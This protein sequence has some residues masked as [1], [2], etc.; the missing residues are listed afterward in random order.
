MSLLGRNLNCI[1]RGM[2]PKALDRERPLASCECSKTEIKSR[3]RSP[4]QF[5]IYLPSLC[6]AML[7]LAPQKGTRQID[8][9][10]F[11]AA[12][13][14]VRGGKIARLYDHDS[15]RNF[16]ALAGK[17]SLY[18]N[19]PPF[20]A[21]A[22]L[23]FAYMSYNTFLLTV[24]IGSYLLLALAVWLIP[25]WFP[26]ITHARPLLLCFPPFLLSV[27]VGQDTIFLTL[28]VGYGAYLILRNKDLEGGITLA[29]AL[30][31][32]HLLWAVP[33]ALAAQSRWRAL[34]GFC[35]MGFLLAI[36]SLAL[37]GPQGIGQWL[38]VLKAPTT[39]TV[40]ELMGNIRGLSYQMGTVPSVAIAG[41][42]AVAFVVCAW[43]RSTQV[44]LAAAFFVG[45][46]LVPHS[47]LQDYSPA[48]VAALL[49]PYAAISF[50]VL[51]PWPLFWPEKTISGIPY[52][53]TALVFLCALAFW[54]FVEAKAL[55]VRNRGNQS[56]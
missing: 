10:Q 21:L 22:L 41:I 20:H 9:P 56:G 44:A 26:A 31:K 23:P 30:F 53:L 17:N 43:K 18:Y 6:L 52:A 8:V 12:G 32:P 5:L 47:Y 39:D 14:I 25:R 36:L 16:V 4:Y 28:I 45:P 51:I 48:A 46:L 38:A 11:F 29:L 24:K 7:F 50:V 1:F 49:S 19:R 3:R 54:P 15:Y 27:A 42:A 37:I 33:I 34:F 55:K 40:P 35:G 13:H 2:T